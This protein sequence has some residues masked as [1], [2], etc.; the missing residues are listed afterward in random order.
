MKNR[1]WILAL[2]AAFVVIASQ[3]TAATASHTR[4]KWVDLKWRTTLTSTTSP[5]F[6]SIYGAGTANTG[7]RFVDSLTVTAQSEGNMDSGKLADTTAAFSLV[8]LIPDWTVADTLGA[9]TDTSIAI[10]FA[11]FKDPNSAITPEMTAVNYFGLQ[12][13][14]NGTDWVAATALS[15]SLRFAETVSGNDVFIATLRADNIAQATNSSK[16]WWGFRLYRLVLTH[17][18]VG[19]FRVRMGYLS[20]DP[21]EQ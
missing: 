20:N 12:G 2:L 13:S 9:F 14:M 1:I 17:D 5:T 21:D 3:M 19:T 6:A 11:V 7:I 15:D 8:D 4:M 16:R 18:I 10:T